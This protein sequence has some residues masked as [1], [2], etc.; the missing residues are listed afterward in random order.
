MNS[1]SIEIFLSEHQKQ[2][3]IDEAYR[4]ESFNNKLGLKGRLDAVSGGLE[5]LLMHMEGAAGEVAVASYLGLESELF[6]QKTP[7]RGSY[8]L[9]PNID[10]KSRSRHE[11]DLLIMMDE[12]SSKLFVLVTIQFKRIF[13]HGAIEGSDAMKPKFIKEYRK[14]RPVYSIPQSQLRPL[15]DFPYVWN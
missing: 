13:L 15:Q 3:A 6:K 5:S 4:R 12:P 1:H 7:V 10:V 2:L 11:W 8:D 9:P 14:N